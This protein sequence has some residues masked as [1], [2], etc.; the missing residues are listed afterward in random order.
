M[1]DLATGREREVPLDIAVDLARDY[2]E[3][4]ELLGLFNLHWSPD[5]SAF[6]ISAGIEACGPWILEALIHI[7]A[8]TLSQRTLLTMTEDT[9]WYTVVE[10]S[11]SRRIT[12]REGRDALWWLD[13]TTGELTKAQS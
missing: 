13:P 5:S 6:I 4:G 8:A 3:R 9:T 10:W 7:D 11:E 2:P 1:K 12:L